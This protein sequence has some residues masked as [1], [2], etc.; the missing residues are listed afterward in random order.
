[1]AGFVRSAEQ[2][3]GSSPTLAVRSHAGHACLRTPNQ[4]I[5]WHTVSS[6]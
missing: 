1:M 3:T 5:H 6:A 2:C 4:V